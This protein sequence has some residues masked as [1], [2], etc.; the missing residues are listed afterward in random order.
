[1]AKMLKNSNLYKYPSKKKN[2]KFLPSI[3][4][5]NNIKDDILDTIV[6][7]NLLT[8]QCLYLYLLKKEKLPKQ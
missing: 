6:R 1:M 2:K 8:E 3:R 5:F 4:I 7:N